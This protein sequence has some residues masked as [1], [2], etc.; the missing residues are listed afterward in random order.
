MFRIAKAGFQK[1]LQENVSLPI[2]FNRMMAQ[3]AR[4]LQEQ[5]QS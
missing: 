4:E 5:A 3:R 2:Y 1:L